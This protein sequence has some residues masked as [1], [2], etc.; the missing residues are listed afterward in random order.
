MR[1]HDRYLWVTNPSSIALANPISS[2]RWILESNLTATNFVS[3]PQQ[4][5]VPC[6]QS[7]RP[8]SSRHPD[9]PSSSTIHPEYADKTPLQAVHDDDYYVSLD[10]MHSDFQDA[11]QLPPHIDPNTSLTYQQYLTLQQS[12][13]NLRLNVQC[14]ET[15]ILD[16]LHSFREEIFRRFP[17]PSPPW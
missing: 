17:P 3:E 12:I 1:E 16:E 5:N 14:V 11:P 8:S 2:T 10:R 15:T 4:P 13:D 6:Y 7:D 9:A